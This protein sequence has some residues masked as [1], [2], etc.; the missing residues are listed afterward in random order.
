MAE[1]EKRISN[2]SNMTWPINQLNALPLSI[3]QW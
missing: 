2:N 3:V 1:P